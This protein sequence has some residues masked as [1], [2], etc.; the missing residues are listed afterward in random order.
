MSDFKM[1]LED[2]RYDIEVGTLDFEL[3]N[4]LET[5]ILHKLLLNTKERENGFWLDSIDEKITGSKLYLLDRAT[6]TDETLTLIRSY[7]DES[8][9]ELI[10]ENVV[11]SYELDILREGLSTVSIAISMIKDSVEIK[12]DLNWEAQFDG[13]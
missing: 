2:G 13:S 1:K 7:I 9:Q 12:Y 10:D 3:E 8:L 4:G 6:I 5:Y 11:D